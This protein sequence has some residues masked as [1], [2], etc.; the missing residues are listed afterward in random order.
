MRSSN[1]EVFVRP[2][3][4]RRAPKPAEAPRSAPTPSAEE[5]YRVG[6][7]RPP[8]EFQYKP[9]VSGNPKGAKA[10]SKLLRDLR[11]LFARALNKKVLLPR[12]KRDDLITK[13]EAGF[14]ELA[15]QFAEGDH[16]A[17]RDVVDFAAKLG[18]DLTASRGDNGRHVEVSNE[19]EFRQAL[20]DHGIPARL[21]PPIDDAG[22]DPPPDPPL[23]ADSDEEP[24]Q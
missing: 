1:K 22:P 13:L 7:G 2:S 8:R 17:R 3:K 20:L 15:D 5:E 9:G 19:S 16:R 11:V 21:L 12:G 6:P 10:K 18:I 14:N 4:R 24:E 23:P